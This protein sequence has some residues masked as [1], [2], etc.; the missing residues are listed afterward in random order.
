MEVLRKGTERDH[1]ENFQ[2]AMPLLPVNAAMLK[3]S[4]KMQLLGAKTSNPRSCKELK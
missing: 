1:L 2:S 3:S 4:L